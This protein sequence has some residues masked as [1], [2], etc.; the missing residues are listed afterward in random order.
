MPTWDWVEKVKAAQAA[1]RAGLN[2]STLTHGQTFGNQSWDTAT[3]GWIDQANPNDPNQLGQ[4]GSGA[5]DTAKQAAGMDL[6]DPSVIA[7]LRPIIDQMRQAA[8]GNLS[9]A[10]GS[11]SAQAG[12]DAGALAASRGYNPA[13]FVRNAQGRVNEQFAPQF[14]Q[15]EQAGIGNLL[16]AATQSQQFTAGNLQNLANTQSRDY[17]TQMQNAQYQQM[18]NNQPTFWDYLGS[19]LMGEAG[20]FLSPFLGGL[21]KQL[22]TPSTPNNQNDDLARTFALY[23]T[24]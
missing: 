23:N 11:A 3:K 7:R 19:G 24:W 8:F 1:G 22:G 20:S 10:R 18:Y 13:S 16:N 4:W 12:Q 5:V 2:P 17:Q 9:S 14:G 21:G 15:L 6:F